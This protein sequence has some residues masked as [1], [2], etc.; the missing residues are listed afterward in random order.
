LHGAADSAFRIQYKQNETVLITC[1][2]MK[3]APLAPAMLFDT[4]KIL[5]QI[6]DQHDSSFVLD[7]N[8]KGF[9]AYKS[10][11]ELQEADAVV[12]A[13]KSMGGQ[14]DKQAPLKNAVMVELNCGEATARRAINEALD[15]KKITVIP[16]KKPGL[17]N[18]YSLP[19]EICNGV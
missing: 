19:D 14:V 1:V 11:N 9:A 3:D 4:V 18:S 12:N 5:L 13:L 15:M 2:K 6:G 10:D 7:L 8:A 17:P 16:G